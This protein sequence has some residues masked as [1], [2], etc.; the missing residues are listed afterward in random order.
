MRGRLPSRRRPCSPSSNSGQVVAF[1]ALVL[2]GI[3]IPLLA[4]IGVSEIVLARSGAQVAADAAALAGAQQDVVTK[5]VDALGNIYGYTVQINTQTAPG[6][7]EAAWT[8]N[9]GMFL[10]G[11]TTAFHTSIDNNPPPGQGASIS[12]SGSVTFPDSLLSL[13]GLQPEDTV[14]VQ[15][16]AGTCGVTSWPGSISPWCSQQA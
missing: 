14:T 7:A 9:A 10:G 1:G 13:I 12:V 4:S 5:Q 2:V 11:K 8:A 6:A 16:V 15:G 3:L